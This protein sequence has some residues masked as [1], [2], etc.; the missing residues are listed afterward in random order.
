MS[1]VLPAV[2]DEFWAEAVKMPETEEALERQ[3]AVFRKWRSDPRFEV[4]WS[5]IDHMLE[6]TFEQIRSWAAIAAQFP[7]EDYD[8]DA[9]RAMDEA[10]MEDARRRWQ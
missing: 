9:L 7:L 6:R 10:D 8:Y 4:Y 1:E 3:R 2:R 5:T